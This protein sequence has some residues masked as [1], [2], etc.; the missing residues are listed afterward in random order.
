MSVQYVGVS[1]FEAT[2]IPPPLD[3]FIVVIIGTFNNLVAFNTGLTP[4]S[5][6]VLIVFF[7]LVFGDSVM[8]EQINSI[9]GSVQR[10]NRDCEKLFTGE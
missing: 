7:F 4:E 2:Q 10:I 1:E 6:L 3:D 5:A 9:V 8:V